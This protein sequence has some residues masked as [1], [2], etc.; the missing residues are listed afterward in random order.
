[1]LGGGGA[2]GGGQFEGLSHGRPA[3]RKHAVPRLYQARWLDLDKSVIL[4]GYSG[5]SGY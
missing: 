1:M 4:I 5:H 2:D 3:E